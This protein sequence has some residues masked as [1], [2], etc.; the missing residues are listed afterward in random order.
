MIPNSIFL[1]EIN[2]IKNIFLRIL[3]VLLLKYIHIVHF[4][5]FVVVKWAYLR[6]FIGLN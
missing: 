1:S 2:S 3:C 5:S 6:F 4:K